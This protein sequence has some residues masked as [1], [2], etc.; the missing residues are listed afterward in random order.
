MELGFKDEHWEKK[1]SKVKKKIQ[2]AK[3]FERPKTYF[4]GV[5]ILCL[6]VPV[7]SAFMGLLLEAGTGAS[8]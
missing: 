3:N 8:S 2:S 5:S 4:L 7:L 6:L 1:I